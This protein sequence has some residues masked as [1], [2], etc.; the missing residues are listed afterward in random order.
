[1]FQEGWDNRGMRDPIKT[2]TA[3][4]WSRHPIGTETTGFA[5]SHEAFTKGYFEDHAHFRYETYAPWLPAVAGFSRYRGQRVLDVGCGLGTDL[6]EFARGGATVTGIDLTPRHIV[7]AKRRFE[8]LGAAGRFVVGDAEALPFRNGTFDFVYSCGVLHHTP[9]TLMAVDEIYRMLRPGGEALIVLYHKH[10]LFYWLS[11]WLNRVPR[12][13][14]K[15]LLRGRPG[16]FSFQRLLAEFT[17][18]PGN[19]LTKVFSRG[20]GL[21]LYAK[22][23]DVTA[24]VHHLNPQDFP[25]GHLVP[26]SLLARLARRVG[27]YLVLRG[28]KPAP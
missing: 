8:L 10:S 7:L 22:F 26:R 20:E 18:G 21:R 27:W 11:L 1:M 9:D 6:L 19:P 3:Q 13:F 15:S 23:R 14:M 17:D 16:A 4:H 2:R 12:E 28:V 5:S 24:E 25:L